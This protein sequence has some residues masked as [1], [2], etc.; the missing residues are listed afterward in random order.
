[1]RAKCLIFALI[2]SCAQERKNPAVV[3]EKSCTP[4]SLSSGGPASVNFEAIKNKNVAVPGTITGTGKVTMPGEGL[5]GASILMSFDPATVDSGVDLR[6]QRIANIF[7]K[8]ANFPAATFDAKIVPL[9]EKDMPEEGESRELKIFGPLSIAGNSVMVEAY[10]TLT[11]REGTLKI[12][13]SSKPTTINVGSSTGLVSNMNAL[14]A[15]AN[16]E[17]MENLVELGAGELVLERSCD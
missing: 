3:E 5:V 6:D 14:L 10:G 17:S 1:M 12:E 16:V 2:L 11:M 9:D 15:A 7:F 13:K 8:M 4:V